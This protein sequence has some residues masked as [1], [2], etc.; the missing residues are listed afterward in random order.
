MG[1]RIMQEFV[2]NNPEDS[3]MEWTDMEPDEILSKSKY[4]EKFN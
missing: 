4:E 3:L 1:Y 2:K